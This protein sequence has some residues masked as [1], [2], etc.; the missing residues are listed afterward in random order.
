MEAKLTGIIP[1][2]NE[3]LH[4][5]AAI[6]SLSFADEILVI[7]SYSTDKTVS[8]A[9]AKGARIVQREFDDFSSQKNYAI[10]LASYTWVFLLDADE[11]ISL[12]LK[13]EI[14]SEI[15]KAQTSGA[16]WVPRSN[17]FMGKRI[18][19]SG[20]Q[21]DKV[22]R[23][24][25]KS[26][27]RYNGKLAH[28]EI[29]TKT[30]VTS[31]QNHLDHYTYRDL[32]NFVSKNLNYVQLQAQELSE[33]GKKVHLVLIILKPIFRFFKH[34]ILQKGF[35]DGAQGLFISVFYAFNVFLKYVNLW[36]I[37]KGLK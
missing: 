28:E 10:D 33:K 34:Y 4:I 20:W 29:H 35:L 9:K 37:N 7:D 21:N 2:Y 22:I 6:D 32:N 27:C 8:L 18:K 17:V 13:E 31:L 23:L 3:E 12:N 19:Y 14:I 11:R 26:E 25:K 16:Y 1:T 36:L 5:E 30:T 15:S 24:F